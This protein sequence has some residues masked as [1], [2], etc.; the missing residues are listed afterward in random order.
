[1]KEH[2]H[3]KVPHVLDIPLVDGISYRICSASVHLGDAGGGHYVTIFRDAVTGIWR[4][5]DDRKITL[6]NDADREKFLGQAFVLFYEKIASTSSSS[7][8]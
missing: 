8:G 7:S 4:L 3:V 1:M 6:C 5:G 2:R